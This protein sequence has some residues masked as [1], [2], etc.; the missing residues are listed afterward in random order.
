MKLNNSGNVGDIIEEEVE[1]IVLRTSKKTSEE[2]QYNRNIINGSEV[3]RH[4]STK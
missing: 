2:I 3:S 4:T 1:D